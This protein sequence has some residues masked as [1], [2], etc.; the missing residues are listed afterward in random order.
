MP[1]EAARADRQAGDEV[2]P[3][4][5]GQGGPGQ[6]A[7][8][9]FGLGLREPIHEARI[10]NALAA[11]GYDP[12]SFGR[13]NQVGQSRQAEI[14]GG[15]HAGIAAMLF[16]NALCASE[17][18]EQLPILRARRSTARGA[19]AQHCGKA[20]VEKHRYSGWWAP[21]GSVWGSVAPAT[22]IPHTQS[23]NNLTGTLR[24][25]CNT[26]RLRAQ[27][28]ILVLRAF[29]RRLHFMFRHQI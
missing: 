4:G 19:M 9:N 24:R 20:I 6:R 15:G 29:L 28:I 10:A 27:T 1:Q 25:R 8:R 23:T 17:Q 13:R 2:H 5:F 11:F 14:G 22:A 18:I 12:R 7:R 3:F 21:R 16:G 26:R